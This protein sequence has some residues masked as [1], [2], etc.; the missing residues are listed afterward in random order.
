MVQK[1]EGA[2]VEEGACV[3]EAGVEEADVEEAGVEEVYGR[4]NLFFFRT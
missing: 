3:E 1:T 4:G 2:G